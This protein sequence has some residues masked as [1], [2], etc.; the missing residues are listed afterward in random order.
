VARAYH[1]DRGLVSRLLEV[2][3]LSSSWHAWA[4]KVLEYANQ[5]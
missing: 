2:P 3:E 1:T 4:H 5:P